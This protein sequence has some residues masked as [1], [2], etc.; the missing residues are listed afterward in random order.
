M[1]VL[2]NTEKDSVKSDNTNILYMRSRRCE[3]WFE[4]SCY[5]RCI[6]FPLCVDDFKEEKKAKKVAK[7]FLSAYYSNEENKDPIRINEDFD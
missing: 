5:F 3:G 1:A 6:H 2:K 7:A 4:S